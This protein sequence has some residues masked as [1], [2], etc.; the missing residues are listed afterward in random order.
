MLLLALDESTD[1]IAES[2]E[3]QVDLS[4]LLESGASCLGLALPL[5]ACQIDE[6]QLARLDTLLAQV[7]SLSSLDVNR[8]NGVTS[9]RIFVHCSLACLTI[10]RAVVHVPLDF[11]LGLHD[12]G[13]QVLHEHALVGVLLEIQFLLD[14]LRK[15]VSD[16]F[17]VNFQ[18]RAANE[19]PLLVIILV[20]E[21]PEDV[22]EGVGDDA[23]LVL[24]A[25]DTD[26]GVG[27]AAACLPVGEDGAVIALHDRL[28][29]PES[30]F[31]VDAP[32]G[33]VPVVDRIVGE[34]PAR[35]L[36]ALILAPENDLVHSL[37][38]LNAGRRVIK[39]FL[40]VH[41]STPDLNSNAFVILN[42]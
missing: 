6:I 8:E 2:R 3:R 10:G 27:L 36:G 39:F 18:V 41:G 1:D 17:V 33:R 7:V 15:Q 24:V 26:H 12:A 5:R 20:V 14:I 31:V 40:C 37:V 32:L 19:K 9:G 42:L 16:A 29:E 38:H 22:V 35:I 11:L 28:H 25:L 34:S 13:G 23:A 30:A 4:C 21:V